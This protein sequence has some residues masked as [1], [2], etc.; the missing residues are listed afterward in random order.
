M[1]KALKSRKKKARIKVASG[2]I[3]I[4]STFNNTILSA[5]D[6]NGDILITSSAG[7]IGF[8]GSRK[9]TAYAATKAAENLYSEIQKLG[10]K[11][12]VVIVKGI[13]PGRQ[14]AVKGLRSAGL[15]INKLID[16]T[17]IPHNGCRSKKKPRN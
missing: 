5:S 1:A 7:K 2:I 8:K 11:E 14:A 9:S 6:E 4:K 13:G 12:A 3:N 17:P 15:K 10:M 16:R